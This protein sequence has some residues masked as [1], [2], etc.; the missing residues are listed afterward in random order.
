[1]QADLGLH[2]SCTLCHSSGLR[3]TK[4]ERLIIERKPRQYVMSLVLLTILY[5]VKYFTL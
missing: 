3:G 5:G 2:E 1:V 4:Q